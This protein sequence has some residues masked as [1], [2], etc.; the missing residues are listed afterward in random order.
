VAAEIIFV[1]K[2]NKDNLIVVGTCYG[3]HYRDIIETARKF[4]KAIP[5]KLVE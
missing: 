5:Y 2:N 1:E 3:A 4:P